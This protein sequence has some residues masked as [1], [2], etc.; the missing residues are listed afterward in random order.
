MTLQEA[1]EEIERVAQEA[2]EIF[3]DFILAELPFYLAH[4][5]R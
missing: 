4:R 1:K 2:S 3:E 5:E